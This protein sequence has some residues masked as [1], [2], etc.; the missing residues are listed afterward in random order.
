MKTTR[1]PYWRTLGDWWIEERVIVVEGSLSVHPVIRRWVP[2][3]YQGE[4]VYLLF[5]GADMGGFIVVALNREGIH[6]MRI[7]Y[8]AL[9]WVWH[10]GWNTVSIKFIYPS[11]ISRHIIWDHPHSL[12]FASLP[13]SPD[14]TQW[15][16]LSEQPVLKAGLRP[17]RPE[18]MHASSSSLGPALRIF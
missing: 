17:V 5:V 1:Y 4:P 13:L 16:K 10:C 15:H 18:I 6:M 7:S 8:W 12:R 9:C 11:Y 3:A 14:S 2:S